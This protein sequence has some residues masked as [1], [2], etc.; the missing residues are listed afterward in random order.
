MSQTTQLG[1]LMQNRQ[2]G[3]FVTVA[4]SLLEVLEKYPDLAGVTQVDA[5]LLACAFA[6]PSA[7]QTLIRR[8]FGLFFTPYLGAIFQDSTAFETLFVG[9]AAD[10]MAA[11][12]AKPLLKQ[13][14]DITS[15]TSALGMVW[16]RE[17]IAKGGKGQK[18]TPKTQ[19]GRK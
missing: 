16:A 4:S 17:E 15:K 10:L 8:A 14:F 5:I 6:P 2:M 7:A 12:T 9:F 11:P 19:E 13:V 1:Y 3:Q 18:G